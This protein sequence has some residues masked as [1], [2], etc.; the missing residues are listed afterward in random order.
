MDALAFA[1]AWAAGWNAHDLDR[2]MAHYADEIVFRSRKAVALTG[3]GEVI[4]KPALRRYW[5]E[6]LRRQPDLAFEIEEVFEGHRML[7]ILYTNQRGV[8][9]TETLWFDAGGLVTRA[10]AC[11]GVAAP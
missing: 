4:G 7:V 10:A 6:A 1:R 11:H 2:I 9:T 3:M 5:A 8:R